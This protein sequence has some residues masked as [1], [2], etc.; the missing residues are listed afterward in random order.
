MQFANATE[1]M[2]IKAHYR[3]VVD[4][5]SP[6]IVWT[7]ASFFSGD[8]ISLCGWWLGKHEKWVDKHK[9]LQHCTV[10]ILHNIN[11][12][13]VNNYWA[14]VYCDFSQP[15]RFCVFGMF[16]DKFLCCLFSLGFGGEQL[17]W[18]VIYCH[19][20]L[21]TTTICW[22]QRPRV[23]VEIVNCRWQVEA[24]WSFWMLAGADSWKHEKERFV[25]GRKRKSRNNW[26]LIME[27]K[28]KKCLLVYESWCQKWSEYDGRELRWIAWDN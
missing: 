17:H 24:S 10:S 8:H 9:S 7:S 19:Y 5:K 22:N 20:Y 28:E 12:S 13:F 3:S 1:S 16:S 26:K 15:V 23:T 18:D 6:H 25:D 21:C 27:R 4:I 2:T 11:C 14:T